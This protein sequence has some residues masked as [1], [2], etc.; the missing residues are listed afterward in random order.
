M[1]KLLLL[2]SLLSTL[3]VNAQNLGFEN[4]LTNWSA[5]AGSWSITS[6]GTQLRAGTK[7]VNL[8]TSSTANSLLR[9]VN[10]SVTVATNN[11]YITVVAWVKVSATNA[12]STQIAVGAHNGTSSIKG[13]EVA[14]DAA[15]FVRVSHTFLAT[16]GMTY[17]P[18]LYGR[19]SNGAAVTIWYDDVVIY[20][21]SSASA[22]IGKPNQATA[23]YANAGGTNIGMTWTAGSDVGSTGVTGTLVVR[24]NGISS[25]TPIPL[26][27]TYYSTVSTVGPNTLSGFS[28]R[29]NDGNLSS[30]SETIVNNTAYTYVVFMRDAA[31]NYSA[32]ARIF[33]FNGTG[34]SST[35]STNVHLE[36]IH[37]PAGN[38]LTLNSSSTV[39]LRSANMSIYG[40]VNVVGNLNNS[41]ANLTFESGSTYSYNRNNSGSFSIPNATWAPGSLCRVNGVTTAGPGGTNQQFANFEWN[42]TGQTAPFTLLAGFGT[43]GNFTV[44]STGTGSLLLPTGTNSIGGNLTQTSGTLTYQTGNV[45]QMNGGAAQTISTTG[46]LQGLTI[47]NNSG[48]TMNS[49]L[50]VNTALNLS[51]GT[52]NNSS[53]TLTLGNGAT[54]TRSFG[55]LSNAP[56]FAGSVNINY[57][58]SLLTG[59]EMPSSGGVL[60][61]LTI[62]ATGGVTLDR[63]A[64]VGGSLSFLKG[65]LTLANNNL[66][67]PGSIDGAGAGRFVVT[68]GTGAL[69]QRIGS[70]G[71]TGAIDYPV[72]PSSSSYTPATIT[73]S[74]TAN[75]IA[76]RAYPGAY[77]SYDR[78]GNATGG[79]LAFR[80]VGLSWAITET[81]AGTSNLTVDLTWNASDELPGFDRTRSLIVTSA[82]ASNNAVPGP[83]A[84]SNPY[85]Q[86]RSN[87]TSG[88]G[89]SVQEESEQASAALPVVLEYFKAVPAAGQVTLEW[90]TSAEINNDR[91]E[92]ERSDDGGKTFV[93]IGEVDGKGTTYVT[94][95]YRFADRRPLLGVTYYR[96]KQIDFDGQF[97]YSAIATVQATAANT[98]LVSVQSYVGQQ[99][100][101]YIPG[102][103]TTELL[104]ATVDGQVISR[105][106][107]DAHSTVRIAVPNQP[108]LIIYAQTATGGRQ[109][110]KL[111][112]R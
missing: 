40:T 47:S 85:T 1:K 64:T 46:A 96:L 27:G 100:E 22:D 45:I 9:G 72:G 88:G 10:Q 59:N 23:I 111:G 76:V 84:G 31:Y 29:T 68:N 41:T 86:S 24:I 8:S 18:E 104:I 106:T 55:Q 110:L 34:L 90:A 91:F 94:T 33:V 101:L 58:S 11:T 37:M 109:V 75:N 89:F 30:F 95:T 81:I 99:V 43:T 79:E 60:N 53:R 19:S 4:N 65:S 52:L 14:G 92:L 83:P 32:F 107:A 67:L 56:S 2:C 35:L 20:E 108:L 74:G 78:S 112:Q 50:T 93:E 98:E 15:N 44:S 13:T 17:A 70:G 7:A 42:S 25:T 48:V 102:G 5:V 63:N 39:T 16:K 103:A 105:T 54:I 77:D 57:I 38:T 69:I 28:V 51:G 62:N 12:T 80:A 97:E 73:N 82:A 6:T 61:N 71:K 87:I 26:D 36:G 66:I 3:Y 49:N 21:N